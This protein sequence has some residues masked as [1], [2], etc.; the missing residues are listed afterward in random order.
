MGIRAFAD[1]L[2]CAIVVEETDRFIQKNF[3]SVSKSEEFSHLGIA[4]IENILKR[5]ELQ[6]ESEEQVFE[7]LMNWIKKDTELRGVH[8]PQL[9]KCVRMPF[10]SPQ[11][12]TDHVAKEGLIKG[13]HLCR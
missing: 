9:L 7:V 4:E 10:L 3:V 8:L 5:N 11:F 12:I 6:V 1:T 13:S 2:N